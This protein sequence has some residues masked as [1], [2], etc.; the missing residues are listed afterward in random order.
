MIPGCGS[1]PRGRG[2]H[3]LD[4]QPGIDRRFIP[5]WA[6]NAG[7]P[8]HG[9]DQSTVHP[10]VDGERSAMRAV[11]THKAGSS[12]RG[13]GTLGEQQSIGLGER[14]I[15]AWAGNAGSGK[16]SRRRNAVHPRVGG[17]RGFDNDKWAARCGSSP[18]GRGTQ[19][20]RQCPRKGGRFIPAWAGNARRRSIPAWT[21]SVHP[22]VGGER[23]IDNGLR[24][25]VIGSSPRGRGTLE[26]RLAQLPLGRFIPAWA[27]NAP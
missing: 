19:V 20:V 5:A 14:F 4:R 13:R 23:A 15:P 3:Q 9:P 6:G 16:I 22:R 10:R 17:E 25:A 26:L 18:R 21:P 8:S 2:T 7:Q 12:P 11:S 24:T 1:S 27:G